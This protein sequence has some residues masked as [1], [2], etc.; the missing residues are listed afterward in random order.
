MDYTDKMDRVC[1]YLRLIERTRLLCNTTDELG[2]L[3]GFSVT[4]RNSLA[5]KGG[6]SLF[7]KE[8][9]FH[10][11]CHVAE[12]QT[13]MDLQQIVE[14]Y[15]DVD[16]FIERYNN[17]LHVDDFLAQVVDIFF[18]SGVVPDNMAFVKR[19]L[20]DRHV[21]LLLLILT[22]GLPR[23]SAKNGDVSN[24]EQDYC[25]TFSTLRKICKD[26]ILEELP[27]IAMME[28]EAK[29]HP[30]KRNRLHLIY[31][32][33][34]ILNAYGAIST[35]QRLC[36]TNRELFNNR[37]VPP[38]VDGIWTENDSFTAFWY[39]KELSNGYNLYHY[40][41]RNDQRTLA[42]TK[43]FISF[44][45]T[46]GKTEAI[47]MHPKVI[48]YIVKG[49]AIPKMFIAYL[50]YDYKKGEIVFA[51]RST[52]SEWF[53]LRRLRRSSHAKYFQEQ[54]DDETKD[55][56]NECPD[57]DYTFKLCL[58]ALTPEHIYIDCPKGGFYK[59]PKSLNDV[60]YDIQFEDYAGVVSFNDS[61]YIAFDDK[62]I[63]YNVTTEE[64]MRE[65]GIEH[66][67]TI[68]VE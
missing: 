62:N 16:N 55:V 51:P 15:E 27:A 43:Y 36:L 46:D 58:A 31:V 54:I 68:V 35:Q 11:L 38:E 10:Q 29:A 32:T 42:Y 17:L 13:G 5:R 66:T 52:D 49:Q 21:S 25:R 59:I 67:D 23:L 9:I 20:K 60:L 50:V 7:M 4:N 2:M 28:T 3:V 47:V 1:S 48:H 39:F 56:V 33:Y 6:N 65:A 12:E 18:G 61:L 19:R 26:I 63:Y 34:Y 37:I 44:Y 53:N 45:E 41:L 40:F 14:A 22:G 24:I 8:A 30:C 64:K 57:T